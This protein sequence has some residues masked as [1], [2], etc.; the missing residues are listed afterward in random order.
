M[1]ILHKHTS[2]HGSGNRLQYTAT[3]CNTAATL[4]QHCNTATIRLDTG[5]II[6]SDNT[7]EYTAMHC[8]ILKSCNNT[9]T[10]YHVLDGHMRHH[11]SGIRFFYL[12]DF[13]LSLRNTLQQ[14]AKTLQHNIFLSP[15]HTHTHA[16][17]HTQTHTHTHARTK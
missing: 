17:M 15:T 6:G 14:T 10:H 11:G 3:H 12:C 13:T 2:Q 7:L 1:D 16:P 8:N 5:A 4:Q 9:A